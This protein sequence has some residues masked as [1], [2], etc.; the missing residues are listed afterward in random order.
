MARIYENMTR[1]LHSDLTIR[2]WT[3]QPSGYVETDARAVVI[4]AIQRIIP[5]GKGVMTNQEIADKIL[6]GIAGA[7]AVEVV[8]YYGNGTVAYSDWP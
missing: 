5:Q 3:S 2:V 1:V 8:D 7:E 6:D 4:K